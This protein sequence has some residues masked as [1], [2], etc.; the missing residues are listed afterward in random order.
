MGRQA[1]KIVSLFAQQ[2]QAKVKPLCVAHPTNWNIG[3]ELLN[4]ILN[5][6]GNN[7]QLYFSDINERFESVGA[8]EW[9]EANASLE[10]MQKF[11]KGLNL[12]DE[13]LNYDFWVPV[14]EVWNNFKPPS[15]PNADNIS[16]IMITKTT[17]MRC[18]SA[19][20]VAVNKLL[21]NIAPNES[22]KNSAIGYL[23]LHLP[24]VCFRG[25]NFS[26]NLMEC[27]DDKIKEIINN[28]EAISKNQKDASGDKKIILLKEIFGTK[29]PTGSEIK[30]LKSDKIV[31]L[32]QYLE[33]SL[34]TSML[35]QDVRE[36]REYCARNIWRLQNLIDDVEAAI[37]IAQR[38]FSARIGEYKK[39][40]KTLI[41]IVN[42]T[43]GLWSIR[44]KMNFV[45]SGL[46]NFSDNFCNDHSACT[47]FIWWSQCSTAHLN[48]YLPTQE[49]I[50]NIASG[51]G[52]RC[53]TYVPLFFRI[54]LKSFTLSPYMEGLLSKCILYSKTT[55]CESYFHWLGIMVPKW[56][57]VTKGEYALREAAAYIAFCKRQD[58]K[59]LFT[60]KL[61]QHKNASTLV[62]TAG[63]K[64]GKYERYVVEAILDIVSSD[65]STVNAGQ[66][67][68]DKINARLQKR[69]KRLDML[70]EKLES[71]ITAQNLKMGPVKHEYRTAGG[72]GVLSGRQYQ[73]SATSANPVPP[74][75]F[76]KEDL[77][78]SDVDRQRLSNIWDWTKS[79]KASRMAPSELHCDI[80]SGHR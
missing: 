2:I 37:S 20:A 35:K 16:S 43:Y 18:L 80:C 25:D 59:S 52:V 71:D 73:D 23:R 29:N 4:P 28:S 74:F 60:K 21:D 55:I 36:A 61:R 57:N 6:L 38:A 12:V 26:I 14:V 72:D 1:V 75:P 24:S 9:T 50:N 32:A 15:A 42:E 48:E 8:K 53:N 45:L 30:K 62:G 69:Q 66:H 65:P 19:M 76:R 78:T 22:N 56:Q 67:L 79:L 7:F 13:T 49:Y 51:R 70:N 31:K 39:L 58:F 34:P 3:D 10:N 41:R 33:F 17:S 64:N 40:M 63:Q 68:Y 54:F 11:A 47:R 5:N 46:L 27:M 44:F 77:L